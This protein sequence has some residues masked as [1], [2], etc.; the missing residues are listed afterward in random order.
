MS[1]KKRPTAGFT[2]IELLFAVTISGIVLS[3]AVQAFAQYGQRFYRQQ[4]TM[5]SA[6]E[7]R[8]ALDV[9][10]SE[11]R[12]AG[13]GLLTREAAFTKMDVHEIE[14]LANLGAATAQVTG[15]AALGQQALTVSDGS[16]W[17]KGKIVVLCSSERCVEN[18][19]GA[20]GRKHELTLATPLTA[21][22]P[23]GSAVFLLNKVRYYLKADQQGLTRLMRD[24]DGGAST[25]LGGV[26]TFRFDYLTRQGT[27][28]TDSRT[29]TQVRITVGMDN[30]T[31][32]LSRDVALRS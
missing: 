4:A 20:D 25:L 15:D 23:A 11:V 24:V 30:D 28:T 5:T 14:F 8:L 19:L 31:L 7:L 13:A 32:S 6:Q 21:Q 29:A 9:L 26:A 27:L 16:S 12:L 17:A 18:R 10:C 22:V 2:L 3:G 1:K